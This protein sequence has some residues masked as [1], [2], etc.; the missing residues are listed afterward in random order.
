MA[1]EDEAKTAFYT[2]EG[3]FCYTKMPFGL[4]N[5]GATY[6]RLMD[7]VFE[8]QIGR[9]V[10]VYVDDLVIKS[11]AEAVMLADVQET[12]LNLKSANIKLNPAKCSF[13]MEEGR[14]LGVVISKEGFRVS[15][16]KVRAIIQMESPKNLKQ[17]QVLNGRLVAI[18]RFLARH[19][20]RAL[21]FIQTLKNC[22]TKDKFVWT[23][24]A[25]NA[26]QEMKQHLARLPTLTAPNRGE[27]LYLYLAASD[28]AVSSVLLVERSGV[29]TPLHYVSRV[30]TSVES[31]YSTLE[32]LVLALVH[33]TRRVTRFFHD[34]EVEVL[35][36]FPLQQLLRR[37]ELPGRLV[38]WAIEL[39]TYDIVFKPRTSVKGQVIADFMAEVPKGK[40]QE[41]RTG[42]SAKPAGQGS[43]EYWVLYTDGASNDGGS[44]AGLILTDPSGVEITYAIRLDFAST[45][46]EAEYEA[47]LAGLR[48][49]QEMGATRIHI[50]VDSLLVVNQINNTYEAKGSNM[51]RYL[52][53]AASLLAR[54]DHYT[55]EHIPRSRNKKADALSR[56]AS[57]Q[58]SHLAKDV[59]IETLSTPSVQETEVDEIFETGYTW[60]TPIYDYLSKGKLPE[61]AGEARKVQLQSLQYTLEN[62]HLYRRTF[63][64]PL[65]RCV[66]LNEAAHLIE[67]VHE[68]T[69]GIHAGPNLVVSKLRN[70]GVYWPGMYPMA[71]EA[72]KKCMSCQQHAPK[73]LRPKNDLVPITAAWPF[74][75]WGIDIVGPFPESP[76]RIK[77]LIVAV[78]YFTKWV[79]AKPDSVNRRDTN[80]GTQFADKTIQKWC[81]DLG[82]KHIFASVAHPQ[83]NGQ[84]ERVNRSI[85]E[86]VKKRMANGAVSWVE[87]L[88]HVLWAHRTMPKTS[89]EETPFALTYGHEA[90]V[91]AEVALPTDRIRIPPVNNEELLLENLDL[92]EERRTSAAIREAR[93]K[94]KLSKYYNK[95]VKSCVF[96]PGDYVLRDND[97][98]RAKPTGKLAPRWEG[99]YVIKEVL[100]KGAYVLQRLDG[101]NIP[102]TW[103]AAQ[104]RRCYV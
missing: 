66:T 16:E 85:V 21:P 5:A 56:L 54:F 70:I 14:F 75:K 36:T 67:E 27:K 19:A 33:T 12:I 95:R 46:N 31:R 23:D 50:N 88:P 93:Y 102:R 52:S 73:T 45:N 99:P 86:G 78:D 100:G 37:P 94:Q 30:L 20:E 87:A 25:E 42:L 43:Q 39:S 9:N 48:L 7:K 51:S 68:G 90:V 80:N 32:K 60:M 63:A 4:K 15:P 11:R 29:Q 59:R 18:N 81:E 22:P 98:S 65:L 71:S 76:G 13:G 2:R 1:I 97:A 28:H 89:N 83:G 74:Q 62:N 103:N 49:A 17:V 101:T 34:H 79:E 8:G 47:L 82:I 64:G 96:Y 38:K 92:L 6:Q 77:F 26:F 69:C 58:F 72:I 55:I 91:P 3:I 41:V 35:T 57:V 53:L 84:V 61:D 40:E 44:G 10:E 104:L 24:E